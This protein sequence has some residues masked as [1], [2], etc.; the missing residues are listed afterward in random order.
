MTTAERPPRSLRTKLVVTVLT[1]TSIGLAAALVITIV[2]VHS[3]MR[4]RLEKQVTE[5]LTGL[6]E[7][8]AIPPEARKLAPRPAQRGVCAAMIVTSSGQLEQYW[9]AQPAKVPTPPAGLLRSMAADGAIVPLPGSTFLGMARQLPDGSYVVGAVSS[10][11]YD[12]IARR[13]VFAGCLVALIVLT[14]LALVLLQLSKRWLR[15]L[16]S[17]VGTARSIADGDLSQRAEVADSTFEAYSLTRSFNTMVSRLQDSFDLRECAELRLRR[18]VAAAGH[19]LRTPLSAISGYA[20]LA[21]LGALDEPEKFHAAMRRVG[22]ETKRMTALI[23]ELLLLAELDR[24][25]PSEAEPVDLGPLCVDAVHDAQAAAPEW[26]LRHDIDP[27]REYPVVGDA[28]R[29]R[30][31]VTNLLAN[32][33]AHTPKGTKAQ[34][35]L[36]TT[37]TEHVIDILDDG[38]G[39]DPALHERVFEPFFRAGPQRTPGSGLGLSIVAELVHHHDGTIRVL[40][41]DTGCWIRVS[42]PAMAMTELPAGADSPV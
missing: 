15:P 34:V 25:R 22:G 9:G 16:E 12:Q 24:G 35:W 5:Y 33:R 31:I 10:E 1:A 37:G 40:P 26:E 3:F 17:V 38:P 39:I 6:S 18:F 4:S 32:I 2:G 41:T 20:Q 30:Q 29:L 8:L 27:R 19:E 13:I 21:Q 7:Y 36:S 28:F 23:D 11:D 14:V 42:L